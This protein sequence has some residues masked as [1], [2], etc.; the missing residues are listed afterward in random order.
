[1]ADS[2]L[3]KS[4][5]DRTPEERLDSWKEI[6][7]HL[8][9]DVTTAQRWE[10]REGMPVHR[11]LHDHMGSV[12]AFREELDAWTRSRKPTLPD[13]GNRTASTGVVTTAAGTTS[14][15]VPGG[16]AR[17][18]RRWLV[19]LAAVVALALGG[20]IWLRQTEYFWKNPIA[21]AQF[22]AITDF[23]T[24]SEAA[25][26]S[27]DGRLMA[28]LSDRDGPMDVW[29][30]QVGSG[31]FHNLTHG[32]IP[33][34]ANPS[35]RT[36]AFSPD[37]SLVSFWLRKPGSSGGDNIGVWAVPTLGGEPRPYLD[38]VAEFDWS[39][40]GSQLAFHT[41]VP[42]DPLFVSKDGRL[43]S[44]R[45]MFTAPP[46]LHSH[47]PFWSPDG[48]FIYFVQGSI[49]DR[50]DVWRVSVTGGTPERITFAD[51]QVTYPV[52][53]G[54]R[55]L[56]YLATD[57]DGS[58]PWIYSLDVERRRP[59]RLTL[60]PERYT[61]MAASE[62][63]HR[64]VVTLASP[65]KTLWHLKMAAALTTQPTPLALSTG[66]GFSPRLGADYLLYVS[67]A[68]IGEGIWKLDKGTSTQLWHTAAGHLV[69]APAISADGRSIAF[70]TREGGRSLLNI[71]EADGTNCRAIYDAPDIEGSPAWSP[72]G[73]FI[74]TAVKD[75]GTPRLVNVAV[76]GRSHAVIVPGYSLD[77]AWSPDSRFVLYS[78][79]DVGTTFAV[80]I[81]P[82]QTSAPQLPT[83]ALTRGARHVTFLENGKV[84]VFLQGDVQHKNLWQMDLQTGAQRP[85][86]NLPPG[87]NVTDYDLSPD[88]REIVLERAQDRSEV[89][90][91]DLTSR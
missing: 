84:V 15:V 57:A 21:D 41:S 2:P 6:A 55:T 51:A 28:F 59:H 52:L 39:R 31:E 77:P 80:G 30:T 68:G 64:L 29:V 7:A 3:G 46:G 5:F 8:K 14:A 19:L 43:P 40:D 44:A 73:K 11:H 78:G 87:F 24:V 58:G 16:E 60:G 54:G 74:T 83:L 45:L 88:G 33:G 42:G 34:L 63:G 67:T 62:D 76:D 53:L 27:R 65:K 91:L 47:F 71:M 70:T 89:M 1:M 9:R 18:R 49:P 48:S 26:I 25:A 61:S 20:A 23:D 56:L 36:L 22:R 79:P 75:H 85:L 90:L 13:N 4:S 32:S 82:I 69:G 86:T 66:T 17:W 50:L 38:G 10:K 81:A 37:G 12:Y 35:I 72:D